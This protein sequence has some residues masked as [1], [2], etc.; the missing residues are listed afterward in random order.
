[1]GADMTLRDTVLAAMRERGASA[2]QINAAE[3]VR[4]PKTAKILGT[5]LKVE[6]SKKD[7]TLTAVIYLAA[8]DRSVMFGGFNMCP[9]ASAGCRAACLGHTAGRLTMDSSQ[10]AQVWKTLVFRYARTTF[11][12]LLM[13]EIEQHRARARRQGLACSVRLNGT[14]DLAWERIAPELF[15]TFSDVQFY[16]YTKSLKRMADH[17]EG[18]LPSNYHLTFS[19]SEDTNPDEVDMLIDWQQNVAVVFRGE[20]PES[21]RG[22]T[23]IDGDTTDYR[24]GDPAGVI[25][26]LSVKGNVEDT[27]GFYV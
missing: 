1:M 10:N 19:R 4:F 8:S 27:T 5:S 13:R 11:M 17:A 2:E 9:H 15:E 25:V 14:S 18:K 22:H 20:L 3:T 24:A 7:K 6:K 16:D 26:G 21:W 12:S 23:V